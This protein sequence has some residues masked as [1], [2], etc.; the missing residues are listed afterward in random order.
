MPTP[1][2]QPPRCS[3]CLAQTR[4]RPVTPV[5]RPALVT[6]NGPEPARM[7]GA[8]AVVRPAGHVRAPDDRA[9]TG[10]FHRGGISDPH[11][12]EQS[13]SAARSRMTCLT[14]GRAARSRLL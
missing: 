7:R 13:L 5:D 3:G 6:A 12:I 9:G 8:V 10:A 11:V 14:S 2:G 4:T 1:T